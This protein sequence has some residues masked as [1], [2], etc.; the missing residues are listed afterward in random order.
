MPYLKCLLYQCHGFVFGSYE[1]PVEIAANDDKIKFFG[2][3]ETAFIDG[4]QFE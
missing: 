1:F 3:G 2:K 4:P